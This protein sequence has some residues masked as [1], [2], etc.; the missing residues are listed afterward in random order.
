[1]DSMPMPHQPS[2]KTYIVEDIHPDD[3]THERKERLVGTRIVSRDMRLSDLFPGYYTGHAITTD[4]PWP[5]KY[6]LAVKLKEVE[7]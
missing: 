5:R 1:M 7:E 4:T 2:I 6:F 3:S